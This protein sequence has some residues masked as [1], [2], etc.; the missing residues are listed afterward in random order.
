MAGSQRYRNDCDVFQS[1]WIGASNRRPHQLPPVRGRIKRRIFSSLFR[2]MKA[3]ALKIA[4][5]ALLVFR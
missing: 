3:L 4:D 5:F 1:H 2:T